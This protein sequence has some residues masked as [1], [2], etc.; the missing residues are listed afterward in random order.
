MKRFHYSRTIP[1]TFRYTY[2]KVFNPT[3]LLNST[4]VFSGRLPRIV[5][6]DTVFKKPMSANCSPAASTLELTS[7]RTRGAS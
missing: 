7:F 2:S 5:V 6:F 4:N 3:T 1:I